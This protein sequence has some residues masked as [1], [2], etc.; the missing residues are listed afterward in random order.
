MTFEEEV[1]SW[2]RE[3]D[4][5][6]IRIRELEDRE[7]AYYARY[8]V[9]FRHEPALLAWLN[10]PEPIE[11]RIERRRAVRAARR[12]KRDGHPKDQAG[13]LEERSAG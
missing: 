4:A 6:E 13:R 12:R 2:R 9:V 11:K 8:R 3:D 1:A 7:M 5:G 10:E